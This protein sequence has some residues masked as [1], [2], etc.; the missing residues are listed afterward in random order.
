MNKLNFLT[1]YLPK[2]P[3][4]LVYMLQQTEY[5][6]AKFSKWIDR[7]PNLNRIMIRQTI[8]WTKTAQLLVLFGY[9]IWLI[10]LLGVIIFSISYHQSLILSLMSILFLFLLSPVYVVVGLSFASEVG[11]KLISPKNKSLSKMTSERLSKHPA[12]KIAI[13]GS[14]GKTSMKELLFT[15][16]SEGKKVAATP[17]NKNVASSHAAFTKSLIGDEDIILIEYGEG[18][19]GDVERFAHATKP[20][21]GIITGLAPAHLDKYLTVE[22]AGKDIFSLA[23]Y[24]N[25]QNV[26]VNAE[27]Q[28]LQNFIKASHKKYSKQ[29]ME[30]WVV[31]N[32]QISVDGL[33]FDLSTKGQEL[34]LKSNLLGEHQIGPLCLVTILALKFGLTKTQVETGIS[35]TQPFEHRMQPRNVLGATVIDDTYNGNIEG[36]EAGLNL[37]TKLPAK[38]KIYVT[39]GLVDQGSETDKIHRQ[40]GELIAAAQ[41]NVT[42][43]MKN[44]VSHYIEEEMIK[45]GYKGEIRIEQDPLNFYTNLEQ[46]LAKGDLVL[47]QNDWPDQY[48]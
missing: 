27:S 29:G 16:L 15:V 36:I 32:V 42:V 22:S 5:D 34:K 41:P 3:I 35:K 48:A 30:D 46:F 6:S 39:P 17:A 25:D 11:K 19:P 31:S 14:Y 44:S 28:P 40:I 4:N 23:D 26:Y 33:S 20:D 10:P 43:L 21:I 12:T 9:F 37:L 24:L 7:I 47:M 18:K 8:V 13:A 1:F 38:R 2:T 45:N